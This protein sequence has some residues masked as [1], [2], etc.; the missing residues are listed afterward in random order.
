MTLD[1]IE[2]HDPESCL[3]DFLADLGR[4]QECIVDLESASS[5]F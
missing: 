5:P 1:V 2:V 4:R 3:L